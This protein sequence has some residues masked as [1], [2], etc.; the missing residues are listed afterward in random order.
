M[1]PTL[2]SAVRAACAAYPQL[3]V[4][5]E[6][7]GGYVAE[8]VPKSALDS[9]HVRDLLIAFGCVRGVPGAAELFSKHCLGDIGA[10]LS[11]LDPSPAF[12]DE[13]AQ[14]VREKL[15]VGAS[16]KIAEYR[17]L[18]PLRGWVRVVAMRVALKRRRRKSE[19]AD[20]SD[21]P[22]QKLAEGAL[23]PELEVIRDRYKPEFEDAFRA[24]LAALPE[25]D[26]TLL[27]LH[28]RDGIGIDR[29]GATYKVHRAT[30]ARWLQGIRERL[31]ED[32]R[33]RVQEKLGLTAGELDSLMRAVVSQL[34]VSIF[35]LLSD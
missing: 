8:R 13:I 3:R 7:F 25:K 2:D 6:E 17:G 28:H 9:A 32:T 34:D 16:P 23:G 20:H 1:D 21:E 14:A 15:L 29:L 11:R 27:R 4:S 12:A 33:R 26:R 22:L 24:A 30:A 10:A 18:G 35:R 19:S 31:L 5:P